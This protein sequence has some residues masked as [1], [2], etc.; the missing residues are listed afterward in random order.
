[1]QWSILTLPEHLPDSMQHC[2]KIVAQLSVSV[3]DRPARHPA[4]KFVH[5]IRELS[6]L[7]ITRRHLVSILTRPVVV[8]FEG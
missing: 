7:R 4:A 6:S 8:T 5:H 1:M 3:T 2:I